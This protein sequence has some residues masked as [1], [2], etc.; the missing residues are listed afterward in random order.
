MKPLWPVARNRYMQNLH[1]TAVGNEPTTGRLVGQGIVA[2]VLV[3]IIILA[4]AAFWDPTIRVLHVFEALPYV[5][6]AFLC[7]RQSKVGYAFG[8]AGGALWLWMAWGLTTFVKNGFQMFA[9][10]IRTHQLHR[11]DL[12][13]AIPAWASML[14]LAVLSIWGYSRLAHKSFRDLVIF[15]LAFVAI[16]AF[17]LAIFAA[18]TPRYLEMY[19]P[20]LKLF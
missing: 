11:P 5:A 14:A 19:R 6:V 10:S 9:L 7:V 1:V 8:V 2:S 3:F 4:I 12:L 18:F 20:V 15:I 13:I 16:T 17:Y